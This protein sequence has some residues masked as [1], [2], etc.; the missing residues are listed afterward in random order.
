MRSGDWRVV[1]RLGAG[2]LL[3]ALLVIFP[4]V[5][6]SFQVSFVNSAFIAAIGALGLHVVMGLAGLVTA[7]NAALLAIGAYLSATLSIYLDVPFPLVVVLACL[8]GAAVGVIVGLPALRVEGIYLAIATLALHFVVIYFC[9]EYQSNAVGSGGFFVPAAEIFGWRITTNARWYVFLA[10]CLAVI[11]VAVESLKRS[12]YGRA[13]MLLKAA[14]LVA[15]VQGIRPAKYKI[16]AFVFSSGLIAFSGSLMAYYHQTVYIE[17]YTLELAIQYLAMVI[18]GGTGSTGGAIAG[19]FF[20]TLVPV[21]VSRLVVVLPRDFFFS[22]M[23]RQHGGD[24][25]VILYGALVVGFLMFQPG[26]LATWGRRIAERLD[27]LA[28]NRTKEAGP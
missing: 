4:V 7:G 28:A 22:G 8:A 25:Q 12:R 5:A 16:I 14:P 2:G 27:R 23:L 13:W 26:G 19:A 11:A 6:P 21:L 20:V 18:I 24:I 10:S 3:L 15:V 9:N 1:W 17:S